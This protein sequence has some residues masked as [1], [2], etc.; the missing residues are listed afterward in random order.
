MENNND[1]FEFIG[2]DIYS[3]AS[4]AEENY[5]DIVSD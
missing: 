3:S 1:S 2:D 4:A 5:E